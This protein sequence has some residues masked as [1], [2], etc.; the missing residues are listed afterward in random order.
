M[1]WEFEQ[2]LA[3][4]KATV[5]GVLSGRITPEARRADFDEDVVYFSVRAAEIHDPAWL[6]QVIAE[7]AQTGTDPATISLVLDCMGP[8]RPQ[9]EGLIHRAE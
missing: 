3:D 4:A 7:S 8:L 1:Q 9:A 5:L 6:L 2:R